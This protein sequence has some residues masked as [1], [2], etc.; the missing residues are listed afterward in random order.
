LSAFG[1]GFG[2]IHQMRVKASLTRDRSLFTHSIGDGSRAG[3]YQ[4]NSW[5]RCRSPFLRKRRNASRTWV[6][7]VGWPGIQALPISITIEP[8]SV[9][10]SRRR[11]ANLANQRMY[12]SPCKLP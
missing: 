2:D 1:R 12:S 10:M 5:Q 4:M 8:S 6:D 7:I 11:G 3:L 9:T